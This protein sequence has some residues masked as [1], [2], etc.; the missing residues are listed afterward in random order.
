MAASTAATLRWCGRSR[1]TACL[2][3]V[4]AAARWA[5]APQRLTDLLGC[6]EV[7][8][9]KLAAS[10]NGRS[11]RGIQTRSGMSNNQRRVTT[12]VITGLQSFIAMQE[13]QKIRALR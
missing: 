8:L 9:G 11:R 4:V 1:A 7:L 13:L 3:R 12:L 5:R 6:S 2:N 10:P